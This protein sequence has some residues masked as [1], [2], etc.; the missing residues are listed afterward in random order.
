MAKKKAERAVYSN[1]D[2][3]IDSANKRYGEGVITEDEDNL[4]NIEFV[5][6]NLVGLDFV[7][8]GGRPKG[9]IIE[10]FGPESSGKSSLC[11]HMIGIAQR[12]GGTAVL[13]D[14][15]YSW[16]SDYAKSH[17]INPNALKLVRPD[18]GEQ[19]L[20]IVEDIVRSRLA[21]IIV[22]DSVAALVPKMEADG[23][24]GDQHIGLQA[25]MMS[26]AL[27]KLTAIVKKS[28]CTV[29]FINQIRLKVGVMFGNPEETPGGK[30]L[31]FYSSIRLDV[32]RKGWIGSHD[33]PLGINQKV[34]AVKNKVAPPFREVELQ[35]SFKSGYSS[36][37]DLL[38]HSLEF[39]VVNKKGPT[40][41]FNGER[42]AKSK[43]D[44]MSVLK[45]D[46]KLRLKIRKEVKEVF[47]GSNEGE[48]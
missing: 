47:A 22:V 23:E 21:D 27:R 2:D 45:K 28:N 6:T 43:K 26:Q 11:Y 44:L 38:N 35:M 25:R 19:A 30:A 41:V 33:N 48:E 46:K 13:V 16:S 34:K 3:L 7:M 17:K 39:G 29:I 20:Q 9:R 14:A 10:V 24:T 12:L 5:T 36:V 8:G 18:Y 32:R 1:I 37:K 15:E 40:Y 4:D 42:I 31:K